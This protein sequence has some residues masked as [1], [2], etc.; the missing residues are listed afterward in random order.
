M[1]FEAFVVWGSAM[2]GFGHELQ[3]LRHF[4]EDQLRGQ[5]QNA[6][7]LSDEQCVTPCVLA[8][9]LGVMGAVDFDDQPRPRREEVCDEAVQDDLAAKPNTEL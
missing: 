1:T 4:A 7:T 5:T 3:R 8:S 9:A 6:E 2:Q